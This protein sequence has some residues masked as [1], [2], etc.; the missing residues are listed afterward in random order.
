MYYDVI[1]T[2]EPQLSEEHMTSFHRFSYVEMDDYLGYDIIMDN[3]R[4]YMADNILKTWDL[5]DL[6]EYRYLITYTHHSD[7][8]KVVLPDVSS[9]IPDEV[10]LNIISDNTLS[11]V[12]EKER[13]GQ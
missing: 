8:W 4:Q 1:I 10:Y 3:Q 6:V 7:D 12:L 11:L 2:G 5:F 9:I 13:H